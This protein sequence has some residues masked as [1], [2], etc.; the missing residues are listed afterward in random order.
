MSN[1]RLLVFHTFTSD[2]IPQSSH[3]GGHG[4]DKCTSSRPVAE[5][6]QTTLSPVIGYPNHQNDWE[7]RDKRTRFT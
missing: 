4:N 2:G 6:C 1:Q 7:R 5:S 3:R